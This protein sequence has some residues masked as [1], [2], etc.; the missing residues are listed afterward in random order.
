EDSLIENLRRCALGDQP[1]A[2]ADQATPGSRATVPGPDVAAAEPPVRLGQ[3]ELLEPLGR[4]GMGVGDKAR[5]VPLNRVGALK[6]ALGGPVLGTEGFARF[7][8]ESEAIARLQHD[9]IVRVYEC[10]EHDGR[11]YFSMDYVEGGSLAQKLAGT[12][13]SERE[14][15]TLVQTL[16][17]AV[18]FAHR[19]HIIH[20]DLKPANVLIGADG[21]VKL[22]DF[23]LAKLLDAEQGQTRGDAVMGTASYM[24]P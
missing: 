9:N 4:G 17:R 20:R 13:L 14:A 7:Q 5:P 24:A 10:G 8:V 15:A 21:A 11:P 19:H 18:H 1:T 23:G 6:L 22:T 3:Y 12:P 16:A 2:D